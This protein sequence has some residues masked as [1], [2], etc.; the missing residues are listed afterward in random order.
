VFCGALIFGSS[1]K[2]KERRVDLLFRDQ[3]I[4]EILLY[5]IAELITLLMICLSDLIVQQS[6]EFSND[7]SKIVLN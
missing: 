2:E 6:I 4:A 1:L 3:N 5:G 7:E